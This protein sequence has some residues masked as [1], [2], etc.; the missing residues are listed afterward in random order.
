MSKNSSLEVLRVIHDLQ[1]NGRINPE[2]RV[3]WEETRAEFGWPIQ[4][5]RDRSHYTVRLDPVPMLALRAEFWE[6]DIDLGHECRL[7]EGLGAIKRT[8]E[9]FAR[10]TEYL[11]HDGKLV[12]IKTECQTIQVAPDHEP[13][14][15]ID[16]VAYVDGQWIHKHNAQLGSRITDRIPSTQSP[17]LYRIECFSVQPPG[18]DLLNQSA[19]ED[20]DCL[21]TM[22]PSYDEAR[23]V[24]SLGSVIVKE[25]KQPAPNQERLLKSFQ[26][27]HWPAVIDSPFLPSESEKLRETVRA[28][29]NRQKEGRINFSLN[30]T[31][32]AVRWA[33]R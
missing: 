20:A 27:S 23:R 5:N 30:G 33:L 9:R 11:R 3:R 22:S 32:E 31:G 26:E 28:L 13:V 6:R 21:V 4:A 18:Y 10:N 24:L 1:F 8:L 29:N 25:F 14:E 17:L 12:R 2:R 16:Y 15:H 7:L 19:T